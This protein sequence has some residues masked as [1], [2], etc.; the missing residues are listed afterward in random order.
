[1]THNNILNSNKSLGGQNIV[2]LKKLLVICVLSVLLVG[3]YAGSAFATA[4][5]QLWTLAGNEKVHTGYTRNT[6]ACAACHYT[7]TGEGVALVQWNSIYN[8]CMACHDGTEDIWNVKDGV[9]T[10]KGLVAPGGKFNVN[11]TG[12]GTGS[13]HDVSGTVAIY[14]APGGKQLAGKDE[15]GTWS[16]LFGCESCHNPHGLGNNSRI[17]SPD[18]NGIAKVNK[19]TNTTITLSGSDGDG[20]YYYVRDARGENM[21][22]LKGY[23][24]SLDTKFWEAAT[25]AT[26]I[27]YRFDNA[28]GFTKIRLDV[29]GDGTFGDALVGTLKANYVPGLKVKMRF[30]DK[31][32]A[33]ERITY[34]AGMNAFCGACHTDYDTTNVPMASRNLSGKY[35]QKTRHQ[36]GFKWV[37]PKDGLVFETGTYDSAD[38][39]IMIC[40][41]CHVAHGVDNS[42]WVQN[43]RGKTPPI[44]AGYWDG[45]AANTIL[46]KAGSSALKR[47]P[48]MATCETCH[49]KRDNENITTHTN[50]VFGTQAVATYIGSDSCKKCH[51]STHTDWQGT[52]HSKMALPGPAYYI[53]K[54]GSIA[55]AQAAGVNP[56]QNIN[57]LAKANWSGIT[58]NHTNAAINGTALTLDEVWYA[59]GSK[60]KQR[61]A[62]KDPDGKFY[63][64]SKQWY[65]EKVVSTS[66]NDASGNP[67]RTA[68]TD[69]GEWNSYTATSNWENFCIACHATG[70]TV[71]TTP[72]DGIADG[73]FVSLSEYGI[74][75]EACHGP[76]SSHAEKPLLQNITNPKRLS[77][78]AQ[79]DVCGQCHNRGYS[80]IFKGPGTSA[81]G[82]PADASADGSLKREDGP[83]FKP[84]DR[85]EDFF[86]LYW[87]TGDPMPAEYLAKYG[88]IR[89]TTAWTTTINSK[90]RNND[91][92]ESQHHQQFMGI[93][94]SKHYELLTCTSCHDPHKNTPNMRSFFGTATRPASGTGQLST[95]IATMCTGCHGSAYTVSANM[96]FTASSAAYP[97]GNN[98]G[99]IRTHKLFVAP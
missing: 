77:A 94:L 33:T 87:P 52:Y 34:V 15:K 64:A 92:F 78:R 57:P 21:S 59:V 74:G 58:K 6:D 90:N 79:T 43:L 5:Y 63:F 97:A 42:V 46:E 48:N 38:A 49:E 56:Y 25:P 11:F 4:N 35:S 98:T 31:D 36:V 85:V 39:D 50:E 24:Y 95:A 30:T 13:I 54:Y 69:I 76:G 3:L 62:Y 19:V 32:T 88:D 9:W 81:L 84:G 67:T 70:V 8:T 53:N 99:D 14:A 1:M 65:T 2:N 51:S 93:R 27:N 17:L 47:K 86:S 22:L 82:I 44:D 72:N 83:G 7:H 73:T 26:A 61:Y 96:P 71:N 10:S 12:T 91:R 75:C 68:G 16:G 66:T 45:L 89:G 29:N 80:A 60:W 23:P 41:T 40:L 55:A 37:G 18:P 20:A 28:S